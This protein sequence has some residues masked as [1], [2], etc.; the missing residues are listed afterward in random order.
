VSGVEELY[1]YDVLR[2]LE[3]T[4]LFSIRVEVPFLILGSTQD[5]S[6]IHPASR[7]PLRQRRGGG[8][9]VLTQ[10]D[11]LWLDWWIPRSDPQWSDDVRHMAIQTG[12]WWRE[13]L[14]A[15]GVEGL[16]V[17]QTGVEVEDDL[18]VVCFAGRGPG[19]V[20]RDGRKAVGLTQWRVREGTLLSTLYPASPLDELPL[21]LSD[22]PAA[23]SAA[24]TTDTYPAAGV[25][26]PEALI[27]D[28]ATRTGAY[29]R[30][31]QLNP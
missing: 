25:T 22:P 3:S 16:R 12:Q 6:L 8:G 10:P 9:L 23:L 31:L 5:A 14:E 13:S 28:L 7:L 18:A 29:L 1:D 27:D 4:T 17:H 26:S 15:V 24:L 20:F 21:H 2:R 19:E 30:H 11:D